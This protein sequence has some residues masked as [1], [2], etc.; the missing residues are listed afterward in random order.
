MIETV[1]VATDGSGSVRR[2][3]ACAL[4]LAER[5]D[6]TVHALSVVDE[7]QI[8][9]LPADVRD[10]VRASLEARA[11]AAVSGVV[12]AADGEVT[13]AVRTGRPASEIQRYAASV[14][15]DL[16]ATGTRG[17]EGE[18]SFLL[19]SVAEAVVRSCPVPVL[20]VRQLEGS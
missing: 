12:A 19:G 1:V 9:A 14:D 16:V 20:T 15:A 8:D 3:V 5:F 18:G 10:D 4:D 6:A 13:G 7:G 2:A 17:R 11:E